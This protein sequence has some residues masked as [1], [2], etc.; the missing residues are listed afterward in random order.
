MCY[1][2]DGS[3]GGLAVVVVVGHE[4]VGWGAGQRGADWADV[5]C[6]GGVGGVG[7]IIIR[8]GRG[9]WGGVRERKC[10]GVLR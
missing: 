1:V 2:F 3:H 5:G 10:L 8:F 7:G 4:D 9:L 6:E